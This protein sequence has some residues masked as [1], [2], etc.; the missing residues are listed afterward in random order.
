M[1]FGLSSTDSAPVLAHCQGA[2]T[3]RGFHELA[4]HKNFLSSSKYTMTVP[5]PIPGCTG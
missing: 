3:F 5:R 4:R 1:G 2:H